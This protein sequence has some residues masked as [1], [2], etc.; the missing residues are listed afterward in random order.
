MKYF[1][2]YFCPGSIRMYC[3]AGSETELDSRLKGAGQE[4]YLIVELI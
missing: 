2:V 1:V 4:N 3:Y